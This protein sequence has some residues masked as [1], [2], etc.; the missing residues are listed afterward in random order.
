MAGNSLFCYFSNY[1]ILEKPA[2][3]LS[4]FTQFIIHYQQFLPIFEK[5]HNK[6]TKERYV[7]FNQGVDLRLLTEEKIKKISEL[8]VRP[9]RIAFDHYGLKDLYVEKCRLADKYGIKELSNYLLYNYLDTPEDLYKRLKINI[10]LNEELKC[11]VY[12]FPMKYIPVNDIN[13][14]HIGK[15]WNLKYIRAIQAISNVT[16][17]VIG[18]GESFFYK[19]FGRDIE[20]FYKILIMPEDYIIF[21]FENEKN[22]NTEKWW[23]QYQKL[24]DSQVEEIR[25]IIFSNEF[26]NIESLSDSPLI[27]DVLKH[28]KRKKNYQKSTLI[29]EKA[30]FN[31]SDKTTDYK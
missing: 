8:S 5:Y 4:E 26:D 10:V 24:T 21:R 3:S 30:F 11:S 9:L 25:P 12:S 14:K 15:H 16:K 29:E 17:G 7:D 1:N 6:T 31:Q 20:E 2:F 13:R 19:A 23:S 28:Y 27:I 18:A 22:G